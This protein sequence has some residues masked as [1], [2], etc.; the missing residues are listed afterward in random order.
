MAPTADGFTATVAVAGHMP[1]M[2]RR[3]NGTIDRAGQPG[4][5]LGMHDDVDI[6][7]QT[8]HLHPG[9][10]LLLWTDGVTER[11]DGPRQFGEDHLRDVF[12]AIPA[13]QAATA[14]AR[15]IADAV[16][17]FGASPAQDDIA[18]LVIKIPDHNLVER[19]A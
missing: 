2:I 9:D 1:A 3:V 17:A 6:A 4:T 16:D 12:S 18:I 13:R 7:D 15:T 8:L 5:L 10:V 14:T 19:V 11:R